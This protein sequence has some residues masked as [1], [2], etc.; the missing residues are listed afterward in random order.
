MLAQS[1]IDQCDA[2]RPNACTQEE[3][4]RWLWQ[5]DSL[6]QKQLAHLQLFCQTPDSY[7]GSTVL[8]IEDTFCDVYV[9]YLLSQIDF[10]NGET[11]RYNA[12]AV[13]FNAAYSHFLDHMNRTHTAPKRS[14]CL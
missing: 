6:L 1:I 5:F 13:L 4:L 9:K 2:L 3:K 14:I 10:A 7:D 8:L 11:G 12:S